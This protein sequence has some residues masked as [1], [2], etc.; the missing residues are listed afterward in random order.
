MT[1]RERETWRDMESERIYSHD[2]LV[3]QPHSHH[4]T[5]TKPFTFINYQFTKRNEINNINDCKNK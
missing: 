5:P 2:V 4:T 1:E 3:I